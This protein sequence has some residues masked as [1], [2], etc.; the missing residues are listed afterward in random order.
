MLLRKKDQKLFILD[1]EYAFLNF[2]ENDMANY[3]NETMLFNYKPE[4]Y[5]LFDKVDFDKGYQIYQ[6]YV[7]QFIQNHTFMKESKEGKEFLEFMKTKKYFIL[8][9]NII[10]L[11]YFLWSI[12][13]VDF[14]TW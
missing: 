4:Y 5:F 2:P 1:R 3:L 13:Y 6:K 9:N 7:E 12:C 14:Y 8:L 10:N 11:F